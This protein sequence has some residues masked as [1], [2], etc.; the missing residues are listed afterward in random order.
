MQS[1]GVVVLDEVGDEAAGLL[2][3]EGSSRA[4]AVALERLLVPAFGF[5]VGLRVVGRGFDMGETSHAHEL[6]EVLGDKLR[7]V[8]G[9]DPGLFSR[10]L[11]Q[12][13]LDDNLHVGLGHGFAQLVVND[14]ASASV[15]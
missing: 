9:D 2:N 15:G 4:D 5:A 10:M 7:A 6:L 1:H 8:D 13:A 12:S 11:F 3:V 14:G